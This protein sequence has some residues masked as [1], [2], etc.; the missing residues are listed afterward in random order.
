[1]AGIELGLGAGSSR[2]CWRRFSDIGAQTSAL[3][4]WTWPFNWVVLLAH[5]AEP[6]LEAIE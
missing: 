6:Q 2:G 1:M 5:R 3:S 4:I